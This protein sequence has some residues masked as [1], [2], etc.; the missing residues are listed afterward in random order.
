MEDLKLAHVG[1]IVKDIEV[2]GA[3]LKKVFNVSEMSAKV[4]D[5]NQQAFLQMYKSGDC[6]LE[7]ISPNGEKSNVNT[8]INHFGDHLAHLCFE[9][10][11]LEATL[12]RV[13]GEGVLVFRPPTPAILF[14]RKKVAFAL[15][16]NKIV[17]EFV[18]KGWNSDQ[19]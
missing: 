14:D 4:E 18:E 19:Q 15:L 5:N 10:S 12:K 17:I 13:R 11:D 16:P 9:T 8:A 3:F 7:L 1:I 6:Y 2:F